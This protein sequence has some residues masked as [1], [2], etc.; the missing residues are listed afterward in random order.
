V[1]RF[2]REGAREAGRDFSKIE[3]MARPCLGLRRPEDR[4]RTRA[5]VSCPG[6]QPRDD[7]IS[8]Y[9]PEELP[10]RSPFRQRPRKYD[11]LHHCE[12]GSDNAE[13]V[14]DEVVDR[15]CIIARRRTSQKLDRLRKVA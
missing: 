13:F 10:P 6:L 4:T 3:V 11:Y 12:V 8:K 5:L 15:F 2:V 1:P 9:K 7:L 14:T